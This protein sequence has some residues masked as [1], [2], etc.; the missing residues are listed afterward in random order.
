MFS[1]YVNKVYSIK[2]DPVNPSQKAMAKSLLNNLLGRFGI[3]LEKPIT[4]V[5]SNETFQ[6]KMLMCKIMSY[7]QISEH[8]VLVSYV[9]SL[10]YDIITSHGLDYLKIVSNF[11]DNEL[12]PLTTTSIVISAAITAYARIHISKLKLDILKLGGEIYYSDTDSIVTYI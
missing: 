3:N 11:K 10:D 1:K 2:A 4:E 9:P 12:R 7:K 8:R 6:K 5:L